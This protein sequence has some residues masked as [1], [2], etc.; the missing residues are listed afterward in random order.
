MALQ[1]S[2]AVRNGSLD[3]IETVVGTGPVLRILSGSKPADCAAAETGTVLAEITLPS[4]W[5]LAA[6]SG[7]KAKDGTWS[8]LSANATG[9]AGYFR[10]YDSTIST[11]HLQ[12]EC[13]DTAGAG[14][15]KLSTTAVV[16][17]EPVT[18]ATFALTAGNP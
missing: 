10:I 9:T 3:S 5:M 2:V 8:D 11:C 18:V 16:A 15:M 13:T 4:D 7:V 1:L 17:T 12:G 6:A 14:P